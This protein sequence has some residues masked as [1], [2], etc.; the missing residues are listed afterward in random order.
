MG[1]VEAMNHREAVRARSGPAL[2]R[3]LFGL[4]PVAGAVV[5]DA[6]VSA[7]SGCAS[8][9]ERRPAAPYVGAQGASWSVVLPAAEVADTGWYA[10]SENNEEYARRN[11]ALGV[12]AR[13]SD[14]PLDAW[15]DPGYPTLD[16][17]RRITV[18]RQAESTT[19]FQSTTATTTSTWPWGGRSVR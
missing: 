7:I 13:G 3:R 4:A 16:R 18:G 10:A 11:Y 2:A 19:Y 1:E 17:T 6:S 9:V 12:G 14:Y 5:I 8:S 15:P